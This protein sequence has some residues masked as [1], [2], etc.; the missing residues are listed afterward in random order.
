M[1]FFP[2]GEQVFEA[3]GGFGRTLPTLSHT[4]WSMANFPFSVRLKSSRKKFGESR[5]EKK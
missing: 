4:L 2:G 5:V 3:G 1:D